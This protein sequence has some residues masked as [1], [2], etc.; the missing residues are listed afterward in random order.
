MDF[1]SEMIKDW[2]KN[3]RRGVETIYVVDKTEAVS[4]NQLPTTLSRVISPII[5]SS[6]PESLEIV[7]N[8]APQTSWKKQMSKDVAKAILTFNTKDDIIAQLKGPQVI[9][10]FLLQDSIDDNLQFKSDCDSNHPLYKICQFVDRK[11]KNADKSQN[12]NLAEKLIE[13]SKAPYGLYQTFS[14]IGI[15]AFALKKYAGKIFDLQGR[16]RDKL[17]KGINIVNGKKIVVN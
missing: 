12:F 13:L 8:R 5:F 10:S 9:M 17:Q 16:R 7:R 2:C 14:G 6:G 11:I 15:L 1:A 3:M 4:A